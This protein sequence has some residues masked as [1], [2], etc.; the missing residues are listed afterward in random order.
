MSSGTDTSSGVKAH[1]PRNKDVLLEKVA[2]CLEGSHG[3][4]GERVAHARERLIKR[5]ILMIDSVTPTPEQDAGSLR[6]YNLIQML[7]DLGSK[8][9]FIPEDN[10]AYMEK[11]T[12]D[13]QRMGVECLYYPHIKSVNKYIENHLNEFD[14]V[15]LERGPVAMRYIRKIKETVPDIPVLFDT[16]DLHYLRMQRQAE[17]ED[18]RVLK[19]EAQSM[20][21]SEFQVMGKTDVTIVVSQYE[22]EILAQEKPD[23]RTEVLPLFMETEQ[24]DRPFQDRE[25]ILFIGG[26]RHPP[27]ADAVQYFVRQVWPLIKEQVPDMTFHV[28]GGPVPSEIAALAG[29]GIHVEGFVEDLKPLFSKCR[30]SIAPLRF[31]AGVK[32]KTG[33]SLAYGLPSVLSPVALEGSGLQP[34]ENILV[35]DGAEEFAR[36]VIR[37]YTDEALWT[38]LSEAGLDF[39]EQTYSK[40]INIPKIERLLE[41]FVPL[42]EEQSPPQ[43]NLRIVHSAG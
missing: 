6:T 39:I 20:R 5:R 18:N 14:L 2:A 7:M 31:G 1:Q 32:G 29:N 25:G 4:D 35:A 33:T 40:R 43:A 15:F 9:T 27:N 42:D 28:I 10:I 38:R 17:L 26:F 36:Q 13:L 41:E 24:L 21:H 22:K 8:V 37:L 34:G 30:M 11:H 3:K 16:H 23:I 19:S 12:P